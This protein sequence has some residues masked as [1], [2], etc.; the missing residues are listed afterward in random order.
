MY[1]FFSHMRVER[2]VDLK[3]G[4]NNDWLVNYVI[5]LWVSLVQVARRARNIANSTF[6]CIIIA[7]RSKCT[8]FLEKLTQSAWQEKKPRLFHC[9]LKYIHRPI[10]AFVLNSQTLWNTRNVFSRSFVSVVR[11]FI[12][13][14]S[15]KH[16]YD[17][18]LMIFGLFEHL[19][20]N[21]FNGWCCVVLCK[22][23]C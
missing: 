16:V 9:W 13:F 19:W 22:R 20:W 21:N 4:K 18:M 15:I 7:S 10:D 8:L 17:F 11:D 6:E 3:I 5:W 2:M 14:I 23:M 1:L 12:P